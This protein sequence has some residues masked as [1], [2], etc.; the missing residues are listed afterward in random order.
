VLVAVGTWLR[1]HRLDAF[2]FK[3]DEVEALNLSI[4]FIADHPWSSSASWPTHG[5]L[6][7]NGVP[8]APLFTWIVAAVWAPTRDPS[9]VTGVIALANALSLYPLWLWARRHMDERRALLALAVCAVS[10]FAVIFSRKIWT[11]D[12][13]P[14]ALLTLLWGVEWLR[15][16]RAWSG[17]VLLAMSVL[18]VGQLHQSGAIGIPLLAAAI[19]LQLIVDLD[20]GSR[21]RLSRP[22]V[23]ES[24][25]LVLVIGVNLFL[26]LPSLRSSASCRREHSTRGR[27]LKD[28]SI[29]HSLYGV[30]P[31]LWLSSR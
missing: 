5:M 31:T 29:G 7:S 18:L 1:F 8:N 13:L 17:I 24:V 11:C 2:E 10:P 3:R 23:G 26:W 30:L 22:S 16:G 9:T 28:G 19:A 27:L 15:G 4:R 14:P 20:N 6:S 12:L 25:A 21:V